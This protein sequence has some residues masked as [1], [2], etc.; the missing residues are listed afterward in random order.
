MLSF[1]SP[2]KDFY[3][4]TFNIITELCKKHINFRTFHNPQRNLM[5]ISSHPLFSPKSS[6]PRPLSASQGPHSFSLCASL[7]GHGEVGLG[8]EGQ[9]TSLR[10]PAV[11][12]RLAV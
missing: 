9:S 5:P 12:S 8:L 4:M 2:F 6:H 3:S 1:F 11:S 10:S 7:K